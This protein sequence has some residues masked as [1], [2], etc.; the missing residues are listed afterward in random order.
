[1]SIWSDFGCRRN[2]LKLPWMAETECSCPVLTEADKAMAVR[3]D[4]SKGDVLGPPAAGGLG[5]LGALLAVAA[6]PSPG[7]AV[8]RPAAVLRPAPC[9]GAAAGGGLT[10][11]GAASARGA[12]LAPHV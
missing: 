11:L 4:V 5:T 9:H 10:M 8:V 1:M 2:T 3:L 6:V 12:W 7:A